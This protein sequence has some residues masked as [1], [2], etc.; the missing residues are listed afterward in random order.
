MAI[1]EDLK[2][3]ARG[4]HFADESFDT[5]PLIRVRYFD[6]DCSRETAL[7]LQRKTQPVLLELFKE[8]FD[9]AL[10]DGKLPSAP[11][12]RQVLHEEGGDVPAVHHTG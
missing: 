9:L 1:L 4:A 8:V 11:S 6:V 3:S 12:R 10:Q 2:R 7:S 5:G